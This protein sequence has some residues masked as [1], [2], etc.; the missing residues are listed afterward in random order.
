MS[1]LLLML[2]GSAEAGLFDELDGVERFQGGCLDVAVMPNTVPYNVAK[3]ARSTHAKTYSAIGA[4]EDRVFPL[5]VEEGAEDGIGLFH[6][7]VDGLMNVTQLPSNACG[8]IGLQGYDVMAYNMVVAAGGGPVR[9]FYSA[10]GNSGVVYADWPDRW[11]K[12]AGSAIVG[13]YYAFTAPLWGARV[14]NADEV[15]DSLF[16]SSF[17]SVTSDSDVGGISLDYVVGASVDAKVLTAGAGYVGSRG[18]YVHVVQEESGAYLDLL[19]D[20]RD[21]EDIDPLR[22][23]KTGLQALRILE[24]QTSATD[25]GFARYQLVGPSGAAYSE[26]ATAPEEEVFSLTHVRQR[27]LLQEGILDVE[28]AGVI[29]P[30]P[31]FYEATVRVH[32]P[33]YHRDILVR[34]DG[35]RALRDYT[36]GGAVSAGLVNLPARPWFGVEGGVKPTLAADALFYPNEDGEDYFKL[37]LL[38]NDPDTLTLFPYAQGAWQF[39]MSV[40]IR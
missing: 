26:S 23:L 6:M 17:S 32:T 37:S 3:I 1:L 8:E 12:D 19:G 29:Q 31:A 11:I 24:E 4:L 38:L 39:H 7:G 14:I 36:G 33:G 20:L 40:M 16:A 18:L 5:L 34:R 10:A 28:L 25:A 30:T 2:M 21:V 22:Y 27:D 13:H 35:A 9:V 15:D